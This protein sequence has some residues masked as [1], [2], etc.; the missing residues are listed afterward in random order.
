[1]ALDKIEKKPARILKQFL[2]AIFN[3]KVFIVKMQLEEEGLRD[4]IFYLYSLL[5]FLYLFTVRT[6]RRAKLSK[7]AWIYSLWV[8]EKDCSAGKN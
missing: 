3:K 6:L 2:S 1:M 8:L 4:Y 7:C 5:E